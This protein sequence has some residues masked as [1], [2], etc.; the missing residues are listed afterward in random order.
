[1]FFHDRQDAG[2]RLA[3]LLEDYR[4]DA[5][6][7]VL[8]LPRGGVVVGLELSRA[9]DLPLDVWVTRKISAPFNRELAIGSVDSDGE[10]L[11]DDNTARLYEI[12]E[13]YV[14]EEA[15]APAA[16]IERR[17]QEYRGSSSP[18]EVEGKTVIVADDGIATGYTMMA[19]IKSLRRRG[20][21]KVVCAVPVASPRAITDMRELADAVEC[22]S[23]PSYFS[24]V[25][26]FYRDFRQVSDEEV[27]ACLERARRPA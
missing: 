25:G 14:R 4:G 1:M 18:P 3:E 20:A 5:S 24:A 12:N 22:I 13:R 9:L 8:G 15:A 23:T 19:A 17:Y 21:G 27:V 26:E 7:L 6:A 11:L 10:V 2:R 16:E